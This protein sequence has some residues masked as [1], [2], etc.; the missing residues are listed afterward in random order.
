MFINNLFSEKLS[1]P[2]KAGNPGFPLKN[3]TQSLRWFPTGVYPVLDTGSGRRLDAPV[4]G[5]GQAP[6]VRHDGLRDFINRLYL[7]TP[8]SL[9]KLIMA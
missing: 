2:A 8:Y 4:S 1:F 3:G 6:Q 5:T 9:V 7:Y